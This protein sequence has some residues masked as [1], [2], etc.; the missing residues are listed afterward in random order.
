MDGQLAWNE[1]GS[2]RLSQTEKG[3]CPSREQGGDALPARIPRDPIEAPMRESLSHLPGCNNLIRNCSAP[4]LIPHSMQGKEKV[5]GEWGR[6]RAEARKT[7]GP[8]QGGEG[9]GTICCQVKCRIFIIT[10]KALSSDSR[11]CDLQELR[12]V[13]FL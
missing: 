3:P 8:L 2:T 5:I 7:A 13:T 10:V 6:K 1:K 9:G 4:Y 12:A 11:L